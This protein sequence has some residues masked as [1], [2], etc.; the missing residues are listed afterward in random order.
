MLSSLLA[1][2]FALL[3][4]PITVFADKT[5]AISYFDNTS[6]DVA[7]NALSKGIADMLITD[8]SKVP[9]V[10]IVEREKLETLLNEI[11]LGNSKYFD[12]K[13]AQKLGSGLGAEAILTGAFLVLD[14]QLR[15]DARL[16]DVASGNI[17][18]AESV[19]GSKDDFFTL[20]GQLVQLLVKELKIDYSASAGANSKNIKLDDV[21]QYSTAIDYYDKGLSADATALLASTVK[22]SP[23][24]TFAKNRLESIK[25]WLVEVEAER[26]RLVKEETE[27]LLANLDPS[28][29]KIGQEINQIWTTMMTSYSYS[30]II[31]VNQQLQAKGMTDDFRIWGEGSP[32]TFGEMRY[33]YDVHSFYMLKDYNN[34][35]TAGETFI[36]KY[37]TSIYFAGVKTNMD[38]AITELEAQEKGEN[39]IDA[40]LQI[41]EF[42]TYIDKFGDFS[43]RWAVAYVRKETYDQYKSI[44]TKRILNFGDALLVAYV[45]ADGSE[46]DEMFDFREMAL[47]F[48]DIEILKTI[49]EKAIEIY[50]D[51]EKEDKGYQI[52]EDIDRDIERI[53]KTNTLLAETKTILKTADEEALIKMVRNERNLSK[54]LDWKFM[55]DLSIKFI[56]LPFKEDNARYLRTAWEIKVVSLAHLRKLDEAKKALTKYK[57]LKELN[58]PDPKIHTKSYRELRSTL[59]DA[60]KSIVKADQDVLALA[61]Y[62]ARVETYR[63]AHQYADEAYT[64]RDMLDKLELEE[65]EAVMQLYMLLVA[66]SNMGYFDKA[67]AVAKELKLKYPYKAESV[68]AMV[69]YMPQ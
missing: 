12:Q 38:Q 34:T 11:E 43:S 17:L 60:K 29:A 63:N 35:L 45:K 54:G 49:S 26:E 65:Q 52:E 48:L 27:R 1:W 39:E 66:Y 55:L 15:I 28:N 44:F 68:D 40:L 36:K 20:H 62:K 13:T 2:T 51:T 7:Y 47:H 16:V 56:D 32:I 6:G 41:A 57:T 9:N 22:N 25:Q 24:F 58:D 42:E 5:I 4:L 64:R 14:K 23:G 37:P 67:R 61:I 18:S 69:N 3:I 46:A 31:E 33:Y 19:S 50:S 59:S 21:V 30:K 53:E 8:L 10:N